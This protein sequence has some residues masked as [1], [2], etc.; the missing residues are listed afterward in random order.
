MRPTVQYEMKT[1]IRYDE[2][3]ASDHHQHHRRRRHCPQPSS[4]RF[5][6]EN[7]DD[8]CWDDEAV[9]GVANL[10][11]LAVNLMLLYFLD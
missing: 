3:I 1:R 9:G 5:M 6:Q 10:V 4:F 2:F 11:P 7:D 8:E